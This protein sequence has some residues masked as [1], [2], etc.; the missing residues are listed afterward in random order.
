MALGGQEIFDI[1]LRC[2]EDA[3]L[4]QSAPTPKPPLAKEKKKKK[5]KRKTHAG[6]LV[7]DMLGRL[8]FIGE[9][10]GSQCSCSWNLAIQTVLWCRREFRLCVGLAVTAFQIRFTFDLWTDKKIAKPP[11]L[12]DRS[13]SSHLLHAPVCTQNKL[14]MKYHSVYAHAPSFRLT[15]TANVSHC[16]GTVI[17]YPWSHEAVSDP[18]LPDL[19]PTN[20]IDST[21][22]YS[23]RDARYRQVQPW[24]SSRQAE[25]A[26]AMRS[27]FLRRKTLRI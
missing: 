14:K 6:K 8:S 22:R 15:V 20:E 26:V 19:N 16:C 24:C 11:P 10:G 4:K 18:Y 12:H 17:L 21:A 7:G 9:R 5:K 1:L 27:C 13:Y 2:I 23:R 3:V 25:P